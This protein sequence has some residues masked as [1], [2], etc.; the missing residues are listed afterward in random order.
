[1]GPELAMF[2]FFVC[3]P[4]ALGSIYKAS[5]N[6]QRYLK[7]LQLKAEM[8]TRLL[9]RAGSDPAILELL[10][11]DAQ[12][13]LFDIPQTETPAPYM[14]MLTALQAAFMLLCGGA[15]ALWFGS[16]LVVNDNG[17]QPFMFFG[18]MG[19]ALG[20]GALLSAAAALVVARMWR[21]LRAGA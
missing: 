14:R 19:V 20:I 2:F 12:Q 21:T 9:D 11:S 15:G 16:I 13:Q 17:R 10:K 8:N 4:L 1:M 18:A 6:H 5:L 7:V 3:V